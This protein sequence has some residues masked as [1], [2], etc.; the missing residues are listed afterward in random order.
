MPEAAIVEPRFR[1]DGQK[2]KLGS[3]PVFVDKLRPFAIIAATCAKG[4][5]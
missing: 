3:F 5:G 4:E 2:K 1:A